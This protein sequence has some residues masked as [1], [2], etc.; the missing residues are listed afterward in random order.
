MGTR[1]KGSLPA[2]DLMCIV[3]MVVK[4]TQ[5]LGI[6]MNHFYQFCDQLSKP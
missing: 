5:G 1:P 4:G 6:Q 3:Y 2:T